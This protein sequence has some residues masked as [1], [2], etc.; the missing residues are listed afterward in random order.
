MK[1]SRNLL[2]LM[3]LSSIALSGCVNYG[4]TSIESATTAS[5][6]AELSIGQTTKAEVEATYGSPYE[7]DFTDSGLMTWTYLF[8]ESN[9]WTIETVGSAVL[10]EGALGGKA[11]GTRSELVILFDENDVVMRFNFSKSPYEVSTGIF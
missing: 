11:N 8:D 1:P 10:T 2:F 6:A 9:A 4:N 7:T 3:L 5:V